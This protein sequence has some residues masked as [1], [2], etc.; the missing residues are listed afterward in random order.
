MTR[1]RFDSSV[2]KCTANLTK[3]AVGDML[4]KM[5]HSEFRLYLALCR[6]TEKHT[7]VELH[8]PSYR[9]TDYTGL[10]SE[11]I[12]V[13][14]RKLEERGLITSRKGANGRNVYT[15]LDPER[16]T[17]LPASVHGKQHFTGVYKYQE[18]GRSARTVRKARAAA[19]A[20]TWDELGHGKSVS[21]KDSGHGKSV[22]CSRQNR[23]RQFCKHLKTQILACNKKTL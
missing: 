12:P 19:A 8:L 3:A 23:H 15:L 21:P 6:I 11:T 1:R 22:T 17:K 16:H 14:R 4:P 2:S 13:A 18:E 10:H 20:L 7:A 9:I 5:G